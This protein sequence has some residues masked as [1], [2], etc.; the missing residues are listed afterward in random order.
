LSSW[1]EQVLNAV[2]L[3]IESVERKYDQRFAVVFR[4][5]KQL[6]AEDQAIKGQPQWLIGFHP[7]IEG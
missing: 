6:V 4:A 3:K 2:N 5:I 7:W 1:P